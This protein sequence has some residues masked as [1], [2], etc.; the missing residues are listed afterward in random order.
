M[1]FKWPEA[2]QVSLK[3]LNDDSY[4]PA[5]GGAFAAPQ[6]PYGHPLGMQGY[7]RPHPVLM[8]RSE[9]GYPS[10]GSLYSP[11]MMGNA[12]ASGFIGYQPHDPRVSAPS[13]PSQHSPP[14]GNKCNAIAMSVSA[15]STAGTSQNGRIKRKNGPKTWAKEEDTALLRLVQNMCGPMKWSVV[16]Q[17]M[18]Q[19]TGKQCRERYVNHLNPRLKVSD[20]SSVEDAVIFHLYDSLGSQWAKMAKMIPGR[21]DNGIKNRFHNLRRQL[22]REDEHRMKLSKSEDYQDE[23]HLGRVRELPEHLRGK[24]SSLWNMDAGIGI[25]AA[26]SV[27]RGGIASRDQSKKKFGPFRTPD[28]DGE[29][30]ARCGLIVPSAQCGPDICSKSRWCNTCT[31]IPAHLCSTLLRECLNLRCPQEEELAALVRAWSIHIN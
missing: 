27:L 10:Y 21:T 5:H 13:T 17:S 28:N 20:W 30:C 8:Q 2:K 25:L 15:P 12:P 23:I 7:G 22:E 14:R 1:L 31:R 6:P 3:P 4:D 18:P 26:Q 24:A 29:F 19:R 11:T 9:P 16:A